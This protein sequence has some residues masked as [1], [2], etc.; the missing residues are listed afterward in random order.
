MGNRQTK[1]KTKKTK[2]G[3]KQID[4]ERCPAALD[5]HNRRECATIEK[6]VLEAVRMCEK[7][8]E[9]TMADHLNNLYGNNTFSKPDRCAE[10]I[11]KCSGTDGIVKTHTQV[12]TQS[13]SCKTEQDD[14]G[15][16]GTLSEFI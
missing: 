9:K 4:L 5:E 15:Y 10:S 16:F 7:W 2:P 8:T 11:L 3:W 6:L 13:T 12:S 1:R 14:Y